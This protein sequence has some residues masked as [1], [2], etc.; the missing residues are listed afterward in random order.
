MLTA[1]GSQHWWPADTPFEVMVG[2]VLT[3]SASWWNVEKAIS[4]LKA[5]RLLCPAGLRDV[6]QDLL[7]NTIRPSGYYNSKAKKLKSLA[8]WLGRRYGDD[9]RL[10]RQE[11]VSALRNDL[12]AVYGIGEETADSILLYACDQPIFVVD[13]YTTRILARL[14]VSTGRRYEDWQAVFMGTLSPDAGLFN[15][16]HALLVRHGKDHCR[17]APLCPGCPLLPLCRA[18][19]AASG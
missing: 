18:G 14:G 9:I 6:S 15:E 4:N 11:P 16:Y 17:K 3:Q 10:M 19:T 8:E 13:A 5:Q 12:L 2:A 7:A 1:Y